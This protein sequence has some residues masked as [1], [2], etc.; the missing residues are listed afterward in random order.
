MNRPPLPEL[1]V[2]IE[3]ELAALD[4]RVDSRT[5]RLWQELEKLRAEIGE[6]RGWIQTQEARSCRAENAERKEKRNG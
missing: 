1:L 2:R 6:F 4:S 5:R 3:D